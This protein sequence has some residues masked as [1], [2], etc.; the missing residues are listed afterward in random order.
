MNK[1]LSCTVFIL[2]MMISTAFSIQCTCKLNQETFKYQ[3]NPNY[4]VTLKRCSGT[5]SAQRTCVTRKDDRSYPALFQRMDHEY[6]ENFSLVYNCQ[7]TKIGQLQSVSFKVY[8]PKDKKIW[9]RDHEACE[10]ATDYQ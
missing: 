9:F 3:G 5:C 8:G 2:F 10:C 1:R 4:K 6:N 7:P